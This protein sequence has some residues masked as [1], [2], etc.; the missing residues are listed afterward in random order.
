M[1]RALALFIACAAG[2]AHADEIADFYRNRQLDIVVGT[3]PGG[4]ITRDDVLKAP[5]KA[6]A[7]S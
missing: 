6:K 5:A 1:I 2:T 3:G 4:R 7:A